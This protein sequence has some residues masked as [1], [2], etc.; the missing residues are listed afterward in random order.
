MRRAA[1]LPRRFAATPGIMRDT[2]GFGSG[3]GTPGRGGP[4]AH[5]GGS[6][7]ASRARLVLLGAG[8]LLISANLRPALASVSPLLDLLGKA[9]DIG[10]AGITALP[11][12]PVV[13][14]ALLAPASLPLQRKLGLEAAL[15]AAMAALLLGLL[16]R[17]QGSMTALFAG[18]VLAGIAIAIGNVLL[19]P[20]VKRDF[21]NRVGLVTGL[22]VTTLN[23]AAALAAGT[24]VPAA[25]AYGWRGALGLWAIPALAA[26]LLW[27]PQLAHGGDRPALPHV[28][29]TFGL[30]ARQP[31]AWAV[32]WFMG[33]Q[34]LGFYATLSWLPAIY[35]AVGMSPARSGLMLSIVTLV[36]I[37]AALIAPTFAARS[38]DQRL[39]IA[40]IVA[41]IAVGYVG[42]DVA[43]LAAPYVW[44]VFMGVGQGA[45]FPVAL[46][47]MALRAGGPAEAV[48]LSAFS[49][50]VGYMIA[51][52][53]PLGL[54]AIHAATGAWWP[55]KTF[56]AATLVPVMIAGLIAGQRKTITY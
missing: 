37:P 22:Y 31:L 34:S 25:A 55:A 20:L 30:M 45:C 53:G 49:Q 19:P 52:A 17:L 4:H 11:T 9:L 33:L 8:I 47:L 2:P 7:G 5:R 21:P 27:L 26:I 41:L 23:G 15:M 48:G 44:V 56:L 1:F 12:I 54:G 6:A 14:F 18:T 35:H 13:C 40:V 3:R 50:A 46:T 10:P 24:A 28:A 16:I 39:A 38:R 36:A 51:I 42:V 43:P 32:A 29:G